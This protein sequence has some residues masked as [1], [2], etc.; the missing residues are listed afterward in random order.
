MA[1]NTIDN[2]LR[3][4]SRQ[5]EEKAASELALRLGLTYAVLDD[6]PFNLDVLSLIPIQQ[7]EELKVSA[8]LRAENIVRVAV[9]H[10][11]DETI[12]QFLV[13]L[14]AKWQIAIEATVVSPSSMRALLLKYAQL[15]QEKKEND[16]VQA[17][18]AA[19]VEAKDYFKNIHTLEDLTKEVES[20]S[21][22]ETLDA[23]VAAAYNQQASDIHIEPAATA[24]TVRFRIDGV[25]KQVLEIPTRQ[26]HAIVSRIKVLANLRLDEETASQDGRFSLADKGIAADV[27]ISIIPTGYGPAMVM[28]VLRQDMDARSLVELGFSTHNQEIIEKIIHKPYGLILSTGPTGSG[29]S[30]TLY[31]ILKALNSPEKKIITLEDPIEYRLPGLQQ[32]QI[33]PEKGFT[34]AEGLR[35]ALRQDPD[36]VMVGEIRDKE[37][38]EIALNA[39]LTGHLVLST[40]H[41]NNASS[42]HTRFL[43]MGIPPFLLNGSIQMVI[44]QRLVRHLVPGSPADKPEYQGRVVVS[45]VLVPN[46]DFEQAVD[47]HADLTELQS[48][49]I[50]GGMIPMLQDGLD[51]VKEGLTTETEIYRVTDV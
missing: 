36:I 14:A 41:A 43:E 40:L 9:V 15:I 21:I 32:T 26:L 30:T 35:G 38:A 10:P 50:A 11:E 22:T 23:I 48:I 13:Q 1:V 47:R 17:S 19:Q 42:A 31:A 39:S 33:N 25:L 34:F 8:Y 3:Q 20:S 37:T 4:I 44:G 45:E 6:F 12:Q 18:E 5:T 2:T 29:K 16:E 49:A 27:R 51:K 24:I 46:H 28:R 7:V